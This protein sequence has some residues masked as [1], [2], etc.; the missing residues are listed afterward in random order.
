MPTDFTVESGAEVALQ[1]ANP[2]HLGDAFTM[3]DYDLL[4][5]SADAIPSTCTVTVNPGRTLSFKPC[6]PNKGSASAYPWL[7]TGIAARVGAFPVVLNGNGARILCRNV[8]SALLVL[9]STVSGTGEILFQSDS[10]VNYAQH[11]FRGITYRSLK[12]DPVSIP[13]HTATETEL[14]SD[15]SWTNKVA[16]WFDASDASSVIKYARADKPATL[17]YEFE[18]QYPVICGWKDHIKDTSDI[19][20]FSRDAFNGCKPHWLPYLVK[21]G[22]NGKDYLSFGVFYSDIDYSTVDSLDYP[23]GSKINRWLQFVAKSTTGANGTGKPSGSYTTLTGCK[24]CIMVFGSQ[25]GGGKSILGDQNDDVAPT[26]AAAY[27]PKT[28]LPTRDIP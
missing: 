4:V 7:W 16:H 18:G 9:L 3:A 24:Y 26:A 2:L 20:L 22:L 27:S 1:G 28:G 5:L 14:A 25:Y 6:D 13:I 19:F 11:V 8:N 21:G 23:S 17:R 15:H 10:T 12:S